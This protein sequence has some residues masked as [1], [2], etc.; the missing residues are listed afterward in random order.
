MISLIANPF[1][2]I[3]VAIV[4]VIGALVYFYNT[5]EQVKTFIN[6]VWT[7]IQIKF[8]EFLSFF[9]GIFTNNIEMSTISLKDIFFIFGE[10]IGN[11]ITE[12]FTMIWEKT[13]EIFNNIKLF[14]EIVLNEILAF[15]MPK[16][17]M[18]VEF[19]DENGAQLL[20]SVTN[21]FK[22]VYDIIEKTLIGVLYIINFFLPT[23][24]DIFIGVW[25]FIKDFTDAI[26]KIVLGLLKVFIGIFTGDWRKGFEG[27]KDIFVGIFL[28][29][30]AF[31][32]G[33]INGII[34]GIN[35][36]LRLLDNIPFIGDKIGQIN[37]IGETEIGKNPMKNN[38]DAKM[39]T[40]V[41][42]NNTNNVIYLDGKQLSNV[43]APH[44]VDT[45]R[46][47]LSY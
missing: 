47:K 35:T 9:T 26:L 11:I 45:L 30:K 5:N 15:F 1:L 8:Q 20:K 37:L 40:G 31:F 28:G 29:I 43:I 41:K 10:D 25:T 44:M 32:E 2:L 39:P 3:I 6:Q 42:N 24:K 34:T 36:A 19:W 21:I 13:I 17:S 22:F 46:T 38:S 27:V 14:I 18:L 12:K 4:A 23:I 33:I 16:I 7:D